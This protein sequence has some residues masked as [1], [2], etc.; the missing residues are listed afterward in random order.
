M[1]R[2]ERPSAIPENSTDE[3]GWAFRDEM[4]QRTPLAKVFATGLDDPLNKRHKFY[5]RICRVSVSMS[6]RG[7]CEVKRHYRCPNHL[8]PDQQFRN[9]CFAQAVKRKDARFLRGNQIVAERKIYIDWQVLE[10]DQKCPF[11]HDVLEGRPFMFTR[12][13]DWVR[14]QLHVL[15]TLLRGGGQLWALEDFWTQVGNLSGNSA[16]TC[17]FNWS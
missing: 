9:K 17:D 16:A 15:T 3:G 8:H 6:A 11:H 4:L 10:M 5:C 12:V 14:I 1:S 2:E 7:V 13:V